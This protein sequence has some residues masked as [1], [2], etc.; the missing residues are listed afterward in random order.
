MVSGK[1]ARKKRKK[2]QIRSEPYRN[3]AVGACRA[4]EG[5]GFARYKIA[6]LF[7]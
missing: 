1:S 7:F 4:R 3:V 6:L 5:A 2:K